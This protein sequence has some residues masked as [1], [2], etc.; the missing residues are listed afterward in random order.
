MLKKIVFFGLLLGVFNSFS[1]VNQ[2]SGGMY[3]SEELFTASG[4]TISLPINLS[5]SAGIG[6]NQRASWVGLGF[7]ISLPYIDR[8][9]QGSVDE[10][11]GKLLCNGT[12]YTSPYERWFYSEKIYDNLI[13]ETSNGYLENPPTANF[14]NQQDVYS[15]RASFASGRIIF[16][17]PANSTTPMNAYLQNWRPLK[18]KYRINSNN[19]ISSWEITDENGI[20]YIFG[21]TQ[22]VIQARANIHECLDNTNKTWSGTDGVW[23][24]VQL[25]N[26]GCSGSSCYY[27]VKLVTS[28][29]YVN[30]TFNIRWY[31]TEIQSPNYNSTTGVGERIIVNYSPYNSA[32]SIKIN[33]LSKYAPEDDKPATALFRYKKQT[34][35]E[36]HDYTTFSFSQDN[37]TIHP[38]Y[39][40][41][42]IAPNG[43]VSFNLSSTVDALEQ[44]KNRI[45]YFDVYNN[46]FGQYQLAYRLKMNY[47]DLGLC[48]GHP[49][50]SGGKGRLQLLGIDKY[51]ADNTKK[52]PVIAFDYT[53]NPTINYY[54]HDIF[55]YY[56]N[57]ELRRNGGIL[58]N[59]SGQSYVGTASVPGAEAWS[60]NKITYGTGRIVEYTY[61]PNVALSSS[62]NAVFATNDNPL[63]PGFRVQTEKTYDGVNET[64]I[65]TQYSYGNGYIGHRSAI[66][67][68]LSS[69]YSTLNTGDFKQVTNIMV[70][71]GTSV[72]YVSCKKTT[73]NKGSIVSYFL[74]PSMNLQIYESDPVTS[75]S[76]RDVAV[77]NS[78]GLNNLAHCRG[79]TYKTEYYSN[80]NQNNPLVVM[81][82]E[83]AVM[84]NLS[85][86]EN[87]DVVAWPYT[88][89]A[90]GASGSS[91]VI[92]T[93][94]NQHQRDFIGFTRLVKS[95]QL[96]N[97]I[98]SF[99][100]IV[101]YNNSN[102]QP[103]LTRSI[104][105]NGKK[106]YTKMSYA[107]ENENYSSGMGTSGA[108]I[109][110]APLQEVIYEKSAED[111]SVDF[112]DM[113]IRKARAFTYSNLLGNNAWVPWKTYIWNSNLKEDGTPEKSFSEFNFSLN[114]INSDWNIA[115]TIDKLNINGTAFQSTNSRDVSNI[116][117]YPN[118]V[119]YPVA[120]ILNAK[121]DEC[122]V[123]TG[124]YDLN[125]DGVFLDKQNGWIKNTNTESG[126]ES[127]SVT[128]TEEAKHF[129]QKGVKVINA[130]GPTR[131]FKLEKGKEYIFSAWIKK[132]EGNIAFEKGKVIG[133]DYR[134]RVS[135]V[136]PIEVGEKVADCSSLLKVVEHGDW[137]YIEL[138][139]LGSNEISD[140]LWN[141]GCQYARVWV[142]VPFGSGGQSATIYIDDIRFY[143]KTAAVA[144]TYYNQ[145]FSGPMVTVDA[146]NNPGERVTYDPFGRPELWE[147]LDLSKSTTEQGY[148]TP[149]IKRKYFLMKQ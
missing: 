30:E 119:N 4:N 122:G 131:V 20:K 108:N 85:Y 43:K 121:Y 130:Y 66:S 89:C 148:A 115:T 63:K 79:L 144:S 123:Y 143:P 88:N 50:S 62:T 46:S 127:H 114:A 67:G 59:F 53:S 5:Y 42:I 109:L 149:K 61:E 60:V 110:T 34:S 3:L 15:L 94:D 31:L 41:E 47:S 1:E 74:D 14:T 90:T 124:D 27:D 54:K 77:E 70:L 138:N 147:K 128:V 58:Q 129:G 146:N 91:Q 6:V 22:G 87:K 93:A 106:R 51:S 37:Y 116:T 80:S 73:S 39:P 137:S 56:S 45:D 133:V 99:S 100:E 83:Y 102:G 64:P 101:K 142:G 24:K 72:Q 71:A 105:T 13:T 135:D 40:V 9:P 107:F 8:I 82:N 139:V 145:T 141:S 81:S 38:V 35:W 19:D 7:D 86:Y 23:D 36:N 11:S 10:K 57:N 44:G 95:T 68:D 117:I 78:E 96:K 21:G 76:L 112:K 103:Q 132:A 49:F 92:E 140:E 65:I 52:I 29:H 134:K 75:I 48:P 84:Y 111:N 120:T 18:I 28:E 2:N 32:N 126:L 16:E 25:R 26:T 17:K 33:D 104:N 12:P 69:M 55:G 98:T 136:W 97:G 113:E 125:N 118:G